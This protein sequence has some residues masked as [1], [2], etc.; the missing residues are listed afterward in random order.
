MENPELVAEYNVSITPLLICKKNAFRLEQLTSSM[1]KNFTD[2]MH[3]YFN[4]CY[5]NR[6]PVRQACQVLSDVGGQAN[7]FSRRNM[8]L[9]VT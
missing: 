4:I 3:F 6:Q 2:L 9:E 5:K 8:F 7:I 1:V